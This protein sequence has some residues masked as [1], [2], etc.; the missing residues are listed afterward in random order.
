MSKNSSFA[1]RL[2]GGDGWINA[3]KCAQCHCTGI[4]FLEL[5]GALK[6]RSL[7]RRSEVEYRTFLHILQ[8]ERMRLLSDLH[9]QE[10]SLARLQNCRLDPLN[11]DDDRFSLDHQIQGQQL[12]V[13]RLCDRR[14]D[15]E[16]NIKLVKAEITRLQLNGATTIESFLTEVQ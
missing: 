14:D 6:S 3:R 7:T 15:L 5:D 11:H 8:H 10:V 12:Q 4:S 1:C 2:C 9:V 16:L 13:K